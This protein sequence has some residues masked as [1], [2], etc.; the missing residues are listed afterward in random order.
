MVVEALASGVPIVASDA[1][2]LPFVLGD[3]GRVVPEADGAGYAR[4]LARLLDDPEA[5]AEQVRRGLA[6]VKTF[7]VPTLAERYRDFYRWLVDQPLS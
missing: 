5:R 7:S 6:R 2:E 3:A 1:A 4:E